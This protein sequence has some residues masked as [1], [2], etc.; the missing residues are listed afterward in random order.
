[1]SNVISI[2]DIKKKLQIMTMRQE[3]RLTPLHWGSVK[4]APPTLLFFFITKQYIFRPM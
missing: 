4:L 3:K 1:M 2:Q